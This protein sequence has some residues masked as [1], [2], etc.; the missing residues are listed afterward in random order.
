M[1]SPT[2]K[3][4]MDSLMR[5]LD[6]RPLS[7]ISVKDIVE[8]CGINRNTFYYHFADLP[9]LVEAIVRDEADL[10]MGSYRGITSL[11]ECVET[12]MQVCVDHKRALLHIYNSAN[13]EIYERYLLEICE[14]VAKAFVENTAL[15]LSISDSDRSAIIMGYKCECFGCVVNWLSHGMNDEIKARFLRLCELHQGMGREILEKIALPGDGGDVTSPSP[16]NA[17]D[18]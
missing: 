18:V 17:G 2:R 3:A 11:E 1:A 15:G 9:D 13:R 7:R 8:D 16:A 6:E 5:Q 12:A 4:I 14:Y 10:I